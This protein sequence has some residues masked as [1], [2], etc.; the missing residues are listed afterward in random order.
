MQMLGKHVCA[1][2]DLQMN[3]CVHT[4][5]PGVT[6][7]LLFLY[8]QSHLLCA[9][10]AGFQCEEYIPEDTV[11]VKLSYLPASLTPSLFPICTNLEIQ[12]YL[13]LRIIKLLRGAFLKIHSICSLFFS[14]V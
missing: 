13:T 1:C 14:L 3:A 5:R 12:T 11:W 9:L 6:C 10:R 8:A 4:L 2:V 7:T